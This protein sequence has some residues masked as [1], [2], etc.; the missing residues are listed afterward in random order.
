MEALASSTENMY[1][2]MIFTE[3]EVNAGAKGQAL[4]FQIGVPGLMSL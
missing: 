3:S 4:L 1:N 2:A